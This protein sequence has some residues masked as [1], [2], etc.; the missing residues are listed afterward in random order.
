M[1]NR[2]GSGKYTRLF[3][4]AGLLLL[5]AGCAAPAFE[6]REIINSPEVQVLLTREIVDGE[7]EKRGFEHPW[8]VDE[9]TLDA[10]L[11]SVK[12][13]YVSLVAD[14]TP[15]PAFPKGLRKMLVPALVDAFSKA[16]PD[17]MVYFA[18]LGSRTFLYIA[19]KNYFTNGVMFV[20]NNRLNIA[21]RYLGLEGVDSMSEMPGAW[22][23]DPR[24]KPQATGWILE[25]APGMTLVKPQDTSGFLAIKQYNNWIRI[26]LDR[27][28]QP[29]RRR[30][31]KGVLY[32]PR[33][34][35]SYRS[36]EPAHKREI[37]PSDR[38]TDDSEGVIIRPPKGYFSI[39]SY[40]EMK[41]K[42]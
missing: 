35:E 14:K 7:V 8:I 34:L 2:A 27:K 11:A 16:T 30:G 15:V 13:H 9:F 3:I 26:D 36:V 20:K 32:R 21:F 37:P 17:E 4:A 12:Y 23:L 18:C 6:K 19:G 33:S 31:R 41:P 28:W 1:L 22:R 39:K 24:R 10:I 25:E 38:D 5:L 42:K 29:V 40:P